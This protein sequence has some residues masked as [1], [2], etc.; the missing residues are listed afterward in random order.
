MNA[1]RRGEYKERNIYNVKHNKAI[2]RDGEF[3]N[4][5]Y[6]KHIRGKCFIGNEKNGFCSTL[7]HSLG[8]K[9]IIFQSIPSNILPTQFRNQDFRVMLYRKIFQQ[10]YY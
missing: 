3:N 2:R 4:K 10:I 5:I 1:K 7:S 8:K 9:D 6:A